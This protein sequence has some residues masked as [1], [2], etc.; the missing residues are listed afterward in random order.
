MNL[1]IV[2]CGFVADYHLATARHDPHHR[3]FLN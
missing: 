1:A 3:Q 2:G